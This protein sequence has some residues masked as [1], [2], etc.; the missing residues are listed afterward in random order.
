MS[1]RTDVEIM[2][3]EAR[4]AVLVTPP[5]LEYWTCGNL[6][7]L[8]VRGPSYRGFIRSISWLLIPWPPTSPGHQQPWFDYAKEAIHG[9]S[10]GKISRGKISSACVMSV[11]RNKLNYEYI[12]MCL[13]HT[14]D[15]SSL[16]TVPKDILVYARARPSSDTMSTAMQKWFFK[17]YYHYI[18]MCVPVH[19]CLYSS[20]YLSMTFQ[21]WHKCH[22][23]SC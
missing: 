19:V 20:A 2:A 22:S 10:R 9:L 1:I 18:C 23:T 14:R 17:V 4:Q 8:N 11:W 21:V 3:I 6:L 12:S 16:I 15:T 7:T 13:S 5:Y